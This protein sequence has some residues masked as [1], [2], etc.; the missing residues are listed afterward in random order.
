[1]KDDKNSEIKDEEKTK[2]KKISFFKQV[3]ISI[4]DFDKYSIFMNNSIGQT[5]LYIG[6][7]TL[8]F[9]IIISLGLSYKYFNMINTVMQSFEE[10]VYALNYS[11]GKLSVNNNNKLEIKNDKTNF[12]QMV[13]N[14]A[15]LTQEEQN[16]E[17]TE[18]EKKANYILFFNDTVTI[19]NATT[20]RTITYNYKEMFAKY[21]LNTFDKQGILDYYAKNKTVVYFSIIFTVFLYSFIL[22][23]TEI[24]IDCTL[25][26]AIAYII[27]AI[28]R[29]KLRYLE[30][31]NITAHAVTLPIIIN[32]IY[33]IV[34]V[35]TGFVIRYFYLMFLTITF[36][37]IIAAILMIKSDNIKKTMD[38]QKIQDE[39]EKVKEE[40]AQKKL[41]AK[42]QK[43]KD[44]V[45][46]KDKEQGDNA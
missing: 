16:E 32:L 20:A 30:A 7:L 38:L 21:N 14:T 31:F 25:I 11:D 12:G 37:Y 29:V 26:S 44:D 19:K 41:E 10:N 34:N 13:I 40:L 42:R 27:A 39:E 28:L 35:Y 43:E 22:Y 15:D 2:D 6:I 1:M 33:Q 8:T 9:T 24:F 46:R 5:L 36:I 3:L 45:K 23:I 4:K 18:L 17:K